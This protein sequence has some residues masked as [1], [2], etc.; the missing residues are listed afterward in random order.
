MLAAGR[1]AG[2]LGLLLLLSG[3]RTSRVDDP[4]TVVM[5]IENSPTNLDPRI[6]T[7]AMSE[8]I[9]GLLFDALVRKDEHF[10][11]QPWLATSWQP[12]DERS[13]RDF[14]IFH[15]RDGVR[16]HDGRPLGAA[17]AAWTINSL[18]SGN[19]LSSKAG[20]FTNVAGA[21]AQDRLTLVIHMKRPDASLLFNLSDGLFGVVP[22]G[23]GKDFGQKPVG[24]GPFRFVRQQQ[25][26]DVVITRNP[27]YWAGAP[28]LQRVRFSVVPDA[29]TVALE[30]EKGSIDIAS[31]QLT[32]DLVH[33]LAGRPGLAVER[34]PGSPV[35]Y[36]N[37]NTARG[38][39]A[40]M[41]VRQADNLCDRS[42]CNRAC[43]LARSGSACRHSLATRTLGR[44]LEDETPQ[45]RA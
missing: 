5:A 9:G 19:L 22:S 45:L 35:M 26:N 32:L 30:L 27:N 40:D 23:A 13:G 25:D 18:V 20:A 29:V 38:P 6:G 41:R 42:R 16:F 17:D 28:K 24:S 8:R 11:M 31:N 15:L 7:D 10:I 2:A 37:F 39:L 33:A 14:W 4:H 1:A 21:E 3:C 43:C 34:S 44:S 12:P 36:L